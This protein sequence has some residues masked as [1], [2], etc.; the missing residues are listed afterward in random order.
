M[1]SKAPW[2]TFFSVLVLCYDEVI[3][4]CSTKLWRKITYRN[5]SSR[6]RFSIIII[7]IELPMFTSSLRRLNITA[8]LPYM[9]IQFISSTAF[10]QLSISPII[11]ETTGYPG[12]LRTFTISVGNTG[13]ELLDC[14][15]GVS[16][17]TVV[18]DGLPIE[19]QDAPR[20][21]KDWIKVTPEKFS[22]PPKQDIRLVCH[23]RVPRDTGGGY[24][25][26]IS[27][28][29]IPSKE[30][31]ELATASGVEAA[32]RFSHRS[33]VPILLT[34]PAPQMQAI[35]DAAQPIVSNAQRGSGYTFKLPVR[36]RGN[37]HT[38]MNG[39]ME[40]RSEDEQLIDR[41]E[42]TAGRGFIL[43]GHERLFRNRGKV[44]L[45]DGVYL[46]RIRLEAKNSRRPMQNT[47]PFF[48]EG[49]RP[50]A[51]GITDELRTKLQEQSAGFV[52][53]PAQTFIPIHPGGRRSQAVELVNLTRDTIK[54]QA[55]LMEWYRNP[56]GN[57]LTSDSPVPH[58]R[59]GRNTVKIRQPEIEL[60]PMSRLRVPIIV[61]L[62]KDASGEQYC[63]LTFDRTDV[64]LD[65]S[66]TGRMRRST[67]IRIYADG[68]GEINAEITGFEAFRKPNGAVDLQLQFRNTGNV[69][70]TPDISFRMIGENDRPIGKVK[71]VMDPLLTQ[72][73]CEGIVSAEWSRVLDPGEYTAEA[74]FRPSQN[75]PPLVERTMFVVPKANEWAAEI[76]KE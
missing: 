11:V 15:V 23:V 53:S 61:S 75:M 59:S 68:T 3:W 65:M 66:S 29:G 39:T 44:N 74:A 58:K 56:D 12:G 70:F 26:I 49:G 36:N 55:K 34:I 16:A 30:R 1:M 40:I 71:P 38:R 73:G 41:F 47:F 60:H 2:L 57:D 6:K 51:T 8:L 10:A 45:P 27:C 54:L 33:L 50:E 13:Q 21:C 5:V 4:L 31:D 67:M 46:M 62:P 72:A 28:H 14:T 18:A 17:M 64:Q 52:V 19:V 35:I 22:L 7:F 48:V 63:A 9:L 42:I 76:V 43:P 20:S 37:V 32:I 25:A 69:S 24:Y